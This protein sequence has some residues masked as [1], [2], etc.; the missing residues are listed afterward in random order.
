[1]TEMPT[2]G[3]PMTEL[4]TTTTPMTEMPTMSGVAKLPCASGRAHQM[5]LPVNFG[6]VTN[7]T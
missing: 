1:M 6:R 2:V 7:P 5:A 4:P 3:I